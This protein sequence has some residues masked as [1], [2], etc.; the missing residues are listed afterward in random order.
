MKIAE[1][2]QIFGMLISTEKVMFKFWKNGLGYVLSNIYKNSSGHP[3][4]CEKL[5]IFVKPNES[6]IILNNDMY[7]QWKENFSAYGWFCI[8]DCSYKTAGPALKSEYASF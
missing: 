3:G 4:Q 5:A 2:P 6:H 7:K 1:D 8:F